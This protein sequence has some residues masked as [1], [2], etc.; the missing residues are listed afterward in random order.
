MRFLTKG[1]WFD[2]LVSRLDQNQY[3]QL[4][5]QK[6]KNCKNQKMENAENLYNKGKLIS[7]KSIAIFDVF[8][9][10][11][12]NMFCLTCSFISLR[13]SFWCLFNNLA[14]ADYPK[15]GIMLRL[16]CIVMCVSASNRQTLFS[17]LPQADPLHW[18]RKSKQ[19]HI[20]TSILFLWYL[21]FWMVLLSI[22]TH[23]KTL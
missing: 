10:H 12:R 20:N 16:Y 9:T 2:R 13:P 11:L 23:I 18:S 17:R 19:T 5:N 7:I 8:E 22:S 15:I 4:S 21:S 3:D 14:S 6:Q 1:I